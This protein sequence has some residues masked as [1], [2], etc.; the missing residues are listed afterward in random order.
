MGDGEVHVGR[1]CPNILL[2]TSS[3]ASPTFRPRICYYR[4]C[5]PMYGPRC[6]RICL[7][8]LLSVSYA[9]SAPGASSSA[10]THSRY[11]SNGIVVAWSLV[12]GAGGPRGD[13]LNVSASWTQPLSVTP[14][15]FGFSLSPTA[16]MLPGDAWVIG[17][18]TTSTAVEDVRAS[19]TM[20]RLLLAGYTFCSQA[21]DYPACVPTGDVPNDGTI[22]ASSFDYTLAARGGAWT[23]SGTVSRFAALVNA[24]SAWTQPTVAGDGSAIA[25]PLTALG[26]WSVPDSAWITVA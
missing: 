7:L 6:P 1:T 19:G 26:A 11:L 4:P 24:S 14:R 3:S 18:G 17:P 15:W 8:L 10:S 23:M 9:S 25:P 22:L 13:V 2:A 20:R 16:A 5:C 21:S 12:R